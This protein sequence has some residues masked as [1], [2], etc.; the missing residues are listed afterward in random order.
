MSNNQHFWKKCHKDNDKPYLFTEEI[1]KAIKDLDIQS[2]LE[3]GCGYGNNLEM[4]KG[5][6]VTGLDLSEYAIEQGRIRYPYNQ[7]H[8]GSVLDI[9]LKEQFDLV[10]TSAVIEHVKP[11]LLKK[12]FDE[13]FRVS[14]KYIL[15]IEAYDIIEHEINWH[16]GK[17]EFW[18]VHMAKR[19]SEYP[20]KIMSDYDV[21]PEY[22]LTLVSKL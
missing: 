5:K 22:R 9:P 15:N 18:T 19:W 16:R 4:L 8:V 1:K 6:K 20:V 12:A 14:K 11:E 21:H 17:N 13:M 7:F 2:V 10:F 3:I